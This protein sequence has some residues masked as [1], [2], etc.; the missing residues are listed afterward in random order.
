MVHFE[1]YNKSETEVVSLAGEAQGDG[2]VL[3]YEEPQFFSSGNSPSFFWFILEDFLSL[4]HHQFW[5]DFFYVL[6]PAVVL[7]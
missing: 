3:P 1:H 4:F 2:W 5:P 6:D 7:V